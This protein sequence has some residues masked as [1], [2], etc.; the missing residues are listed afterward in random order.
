VWSLW[1]GLLLEGEPCDP[2]SLRTVEIVLGLLGTLFF[3]AG[4]LPAQTTT[5][6]APSSHCHVTDGTFTKCQDGTSEWSDVP[7]QSFPA[8]NSFLYADPGK[9]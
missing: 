2:I 7:F 5:S 1:V 4:K 6:T 9:S 3:L 8:T